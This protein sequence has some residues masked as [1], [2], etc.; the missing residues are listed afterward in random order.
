[1]MVDHTISGRAAPLE[2]ERLPRDPAHVFRPQHRDRHTSEGGE[3]IHHA[4]DIAH[5]AHDGV[6]ALRE[7]LGVGRGFPS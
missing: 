2:N 3:L 5:V 1:M 7:R 6:G 4:A